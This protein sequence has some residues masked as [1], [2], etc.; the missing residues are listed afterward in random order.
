MADDGGVDFVLAAYRE[1]GSWQVEALPR[2]VAD[3]LDILLTVLRQRPGD[4][5]ALGLIS[6]DEDFFV[7]VRV[8]GAETHFLLSDVTAATD[9]PIARAVLQRL[10]LPMPEDEER[11]QPGGDLGLFARYGVESMTAA[12]ICDDLDLYPED[13]LGELA[14]QMGF[15]P[16]YEAALDAVYG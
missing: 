1:E 5:G 16:Q 7:A 11:V 6:V 9:W 8:L 12:A 10:E 2:H 3:D 13:M 15:G 14:D 4:D